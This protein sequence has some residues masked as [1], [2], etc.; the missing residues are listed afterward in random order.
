MQPLQNVAI[1]GEREGMEIYAWSDIY[2]EASDY[3]FF[4]VTMLSAPRVALSVTCGD[5][6][7]NTHIELLDAA[8]EAFPLDNLM[9]LTTELDHARLDEVFWRNHAPRWPLL[10][11][12][13]LAPLAARGFIEMILEDNGGHENPLL[14]SLASLALPQNILTTPR[15]LRLCDA[16]MKRVEQGVPVEELDLRTCDA[17]SY[18]VQLLSEIVASVWSPGALY[19]H[20]FLHDAEFGDDSDGYHESE[21]YSS[22]YDEGDEG[23]LEEYYFVTEEG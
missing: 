2:G 21:P 4:I 12:M 5:W 13:Q 7:I 11:C 18:T 16:L 20:S 9:K 10:E 23:E 8:M 17:T 6:F 19:L 1:R 15:A 3:P 22:D 14:P